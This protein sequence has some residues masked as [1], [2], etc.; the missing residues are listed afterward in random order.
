W[1]GRRGSRAGGRYRRCHAWPDPWSDW[2]SS[3]Y[4]TTPAGASM[5]LVAQAA[6]SRH[7]QG[8]HMSL[9]VVVGA[10]ATGIPTALLLAEAGQQV[11]LVSR[12]G[13]G[14]DHPNIHLVRAD[15]T[16]TGGLRE[17]VRGAETLYN[18]AMPPYDQWPA[19]W[20]PL[21]ASML[22]VAERTG[23][24]DVMVGNAYGYGPAG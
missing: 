3:H 21:A 16:A 8:A 1:T 23:G 15:A 7:H 2:H 17:V 11:R 13:T 12:R 14:P 6:R 22:A 9:K 18:C 5:V 19:L 4:P 10:G 24:D 20:P